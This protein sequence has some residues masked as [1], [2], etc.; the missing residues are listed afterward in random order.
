[1]TVKKALDA[2]KRQEN[3][4]SVTAAVATLLNAF[5]KGELNPKRWDQGDSIFVA[6][7]A[8]R[9]A[10]LEYEAAPVLASLIFFEDTLA[11]FDAA[12]RPAYVAA[13]REQLGLTKHA[14]KPEASRNLSATLNAD[15]V[16]P[17]GGTAWCEAAGQTQMIWSWHPSGP[18]SAR[19]ALECQLGR[20]RDPLA[21]AKVASGLIVP[22]EI[23][24]HPVVAS[25]LSDLR[26]HQATVRHINLNINLNIEEEA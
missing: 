5:E 23:K 21:S 24:T 16:S 22:Q 20:K 10:E 8:A 18:A 9:A 19:F 25:L 12:Q 13:V 26:S 15:A 7:L 14:S 3:N 2:L 11:R 1:M 6:S 4:H 17:E